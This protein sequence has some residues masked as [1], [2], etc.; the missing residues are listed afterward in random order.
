RAGPLRLWLTGW[1][2]H[3]RREPLHLL[4]LRAE[5]EQQQLH[6][7]ALELGDAVRDL[8]RR[9]DQ[10]GAQSAVRDGVVLELQA[11]LELGSVHP[12]AEVL[13]PR[14]AGPQG[15]DAL[16]L[17]PR[18]VLGVAA[19][20]VGRDAEAERGR[21]PAGAALTQVGDLRGDALGRVAV[22]EVGVTRARD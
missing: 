22:H 13:E 9:P 3:L 10:P 19:H 17:A 18:L 15:R 11:V 2:H 12:L 21:A 14:R 4:E 5:L 1:R 20:D 8:P 16:H 6:A 7:R